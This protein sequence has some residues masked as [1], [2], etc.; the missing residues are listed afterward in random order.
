MSNLIKSALRLTPGRA[1]A[2]PDLDDVDS[3]EVTALRLAIRAA[4]LAGEDYRSLR[5]IL[6]TEDE[7]LLQERG[8]AGT[9]SATDFT[10]T[11]AYD[12]TGESDAT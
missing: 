4:L 7:L 12:F 8:A 5:N 3:P 2:M 9:P 1:C 6:A 11:V 10:G